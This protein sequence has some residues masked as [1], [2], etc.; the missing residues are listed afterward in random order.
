V[1]KLVATRGWSGSGKTTW[2]R[3]WLQESPDTR[4]I[5]SRD[6]LRSSLFAG[7]GIL[8]NTQEKLI[9]ATQRDIAKLALESGRD[10][11]LHDTNLRARFLKDWADFADDIGADF[12][13]KD[14]EVDVETCIQRN[15]SRF[16]VVPED[17]IRTQARKWPFPWTTIQARPKGNLNIEPY[18]VAEDLEYIVLVDIDGT[19][20]DM[21]DRHPFDLTKVSGDLPKEEIINIVQ[22]LNRDYKVIFFTGREDVCHDDTL[23]WLE[24][25]VSLN[26]PVELHMRATDDKRRDS[27]VK[28]EM[29]NKHVRGRYNVAAVVDDRRQVC[30][31]W[32]ALGLPLFRVGDPLAVF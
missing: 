6:D 10:V 23:A 1:P 2:A 13:V 3:E 26:H 32:H 4:L 14:F 25:N 15:S 18:E 27:I 31:M 28:L 30:E 9:T 17:V 7:E 24:K 8:S 5:I 22:L 19:I 16:R 11:V 20:A 21:Q 29:F 12:E